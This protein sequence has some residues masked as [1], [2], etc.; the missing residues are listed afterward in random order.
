MHQLWHVA[1]GGILGRVLVVLVLKL[2]KKHELI[3]TPFEVKFSCL[4]PEYGNVAG[5]LPHVEEEGQEVEELGA[6]RDDDLELLVGA[7]HV[8]ED[9]PGKANSSIIFS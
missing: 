1:E 2:Q 9:H 6:V 3:S 7:R 5:E 4:I 8:E